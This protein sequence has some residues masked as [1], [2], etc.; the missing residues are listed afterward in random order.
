MRIR[1][2]K[3]GFFRDSALYDAEKATGLPLRV[4]YSGLWGV[5]DRE[6]RFKWKP[7]EIKV[8]VLP[9]DDCDM[10]A[11]L[12]ALIA[13]NKVF[14]YKVNGEEFGFILK[15]KEHQYINKNEAPSTIPAPPKNSNSRARTKPTPDAHPSSSSIRHRQQTQTTEVERA[16]AD[17]D[18]PAYAVVAYNAEAEHCGWPQAQRL[19][20]KRLSAL[21][22]RLAECGGIDGWSAAMARAS[23]SDFLT[24][25]IPRGQGHEKWMPDLDFFLQQSSFTKLMEGSYDNHQTAERGGNVLGAIAIA[26]AHFNTAGN[27]TGN[28]G[29]TG[30]VGGDISEQSIEGRKRIAAR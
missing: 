29:R 27:G 7:R 24:G 15:F 25:R 9:Y 5:A 30:E 22:A 18:E 10:N 23:E 12:D 13:C 6:G 4:A 11:V 8:E 17:A 20:A 3:P 28:P 2:I 26:S 21:K 1:N 16:S 19:T 14:K